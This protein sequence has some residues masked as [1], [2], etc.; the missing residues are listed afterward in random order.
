MPEPIERDWKLPGTGWAIAALRQ[1]DAARSAAEEAHV[2][3]N[4]GLDLGPDG[5]ISSQQ[6]KITVRRATRDDVN[7]AGLIEAAEAADNIGTQIVKLAQALLVKALPEM[8]HSYHVM[9][10]LRI[11]VCSVLVC[12]L[13]F[14]HEVLRKFILEDRMRELLQE[15]RRE[16]HVGLKRQAMLFKISEYAQQRQVCFCGRFMQPLHSMGPRAVIHHVWQVGMK[17]ERHIAER[18][19]F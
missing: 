4:T 19:V 2:G 6:R 12:G 10:A 3:F 16:V 9:I 17:S 11:E 13:Y 8:G 1:P 7:G 15:N 14:A 18:F 5:C